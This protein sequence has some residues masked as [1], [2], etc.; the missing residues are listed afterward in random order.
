[1]LSGK[2]LQRALSIERLQRLCWA[3]FCYSA[4]I[5]SI[6]VFVNSGLLRALDGL[7]LQSTTDVDFHFWYTAGQL[8]NEGQDPYDFELFR[9]RYNQLI[10]ENQV[11]SR[12]GYYYP[13]NASLLFGLLA[14]LPFRT[15]YLSWLGLNLSLL[16]I[17]LCMLGYILSWYRPIRLPEIALLVSF[18]ATGFGRMNIREGQMGLLLGVLVLGTFILGRSKRSSLAG[19]PLGFLTLKPS[20]F[21]LYFGYYLL[22]R[23]YRL[24]IVCGL[25][26][27]S[28]TI[29]PLLFSQRPVV[30]TTIAWLQAL[31]RQN[32]TG[33]IDDPSPFTPNSALMSHLE[34]LVYRV[35]NA[36]SALTTV[37]SWFVVLTLI[38]L[39]AYLIWRNRASDKEELLDFGI[40]SALS[41]LVIYHR[42]YDIFLLFPGILYL[43]IFSVTTDKKSTQRIIGLFIVS[44]I[45]LLILP[46]DLSTR[47]SARYP[48]LL[49]S[50]LW[51]LVA[52]LQAWAGVAVFAALLWL[53]I[54]RPAL[55]EQQEPLQPEYAH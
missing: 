3:V 23:S 41:L 33:V 13:P 50:Y 10:P 12:S 18:I 2:L 30:G 54:R 27:V 9:S 42:P 48:A 45:L 38:I 19:L 11:R 39:V 31:R 1:M 20:F 28:F 26:A 6:L 55:N 7:N 24:L 16:L 17:S 29:L 53:K 35:L 43:Y 36:K 21:P 34:P 46:I 51:R 37:V 15:A 47:F 8:W 4:I 32:T 52:P 49:E 40:V 14:Q 5:T 44:T 25:V 22:R